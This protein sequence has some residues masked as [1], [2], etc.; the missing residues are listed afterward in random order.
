MNVNAS[1]FLTRIT[2]HP[3]QLNVFKEF[4]LLTGDNLYVN[5]FCPLIFL[6]NT[7]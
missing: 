7:L 6:K 4:V 1:Y 3:S 5:F 2:H